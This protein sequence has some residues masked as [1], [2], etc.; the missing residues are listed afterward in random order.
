[1][2]IVRSDLPNI[3]RNQLYLLKSFGRFQ[4]PVRY[5]FDATP[6][7]I[8]HQRL[9]QHS[10]RN[11]PDATTRHVEIC[12]RPKMCIACEKRCD[13]VKDSKRKRGKLMWEACVSACANHAV[14]C[15]SVPSRRRLHRKP[16]LGRHSEASFLLDMK[17]LIMFHWIP[18]IRS[19]KLALVKV[20]WY[21]SCFAPS[22]L[23]AGP[24]TEFAR[25]VLMN[26]HLVVYMGHQYVP[27][28]RR[29]QH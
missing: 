6:L 27:E 22:R 20:L 28:T 13:T 9:P 3:D 10:L 21:K 12:H 17:E 29:T 7:L 16:S 11:G 2:A 14:S 25:K 23:P 5:R 24:N 8:H 18:R 19:K 26:E 1:M 4:L 15:L